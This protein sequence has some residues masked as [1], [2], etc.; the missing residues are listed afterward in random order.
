MNANNYIYKPLAIVQDKRLTVLEQD[1][2]CLIAQLEKA[3]GCTASNK[4]FAKYFGVSR[5]SVQKIIGSL[6]AKGFIRRTEK[7]QGGKTI[8]RTIQIIDAVS[9]K[10][11]LTDSRKSSTRLAEDFN[12]VSRKP[13]T[14]TID[15]TINK[16]DKSAS[17]FSRK[18]DWE[19]INQYNK[20]IEEGKL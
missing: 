3:N 8:Q 18:I 11:L 7:K 15:S 2:L 6:S 20:K 16:T 12:K 9:R 13:S 17:H 19:A 4:Y 5:G 10:L 1:Y 14:H